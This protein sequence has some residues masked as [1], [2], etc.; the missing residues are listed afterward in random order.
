MTVGSAPAPGR[1]KENDT[2]ELIN[3]LWRRRLKVLSRQH[4]YGF[5]LLPLGTNVHVIAI[6]FG[7]DIV[8]IT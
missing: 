6:Y 3:I 2:I 5:G 1:K 8:D 7:L 4:Y